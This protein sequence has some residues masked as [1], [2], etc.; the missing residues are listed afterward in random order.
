MVH[1]KSRQSASCESMYLQPENCTTEEQAPHIKTVVSTNTTQVLYFLV[2]S[3]KN[4]ICSLTF[5]LLPHKNITHPI[6]HLIYG[7]V[8]GTPSGWEPGT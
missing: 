6:S 4:P 5:I 7:S 1:Y 2:A 8:Y 3:L